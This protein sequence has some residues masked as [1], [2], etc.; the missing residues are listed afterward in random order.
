MRALG[1]KPSHLAALLARL[2]H[3]ACSGKYCPT[4]WISDHADVAARVARLRAEDHRDVADA[5]TGDWR[6]RLS[7]Q[8]LGLAK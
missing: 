7:L 3:T 8:C 2:D 5:C 6:T 4:G 1:A